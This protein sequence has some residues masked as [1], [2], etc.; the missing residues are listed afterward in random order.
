M[1]RRHRPRP[2][3]RHQH[4]CAVRRLHPQQQPHLQRH[5]PI[6]FKSSLPL[7][8]RQRPGL[9]RDHSGNV[10]MHLAHRYQLSRRL[11]SHGHHKPPPVLRDKRILIF[12]G[13]P[14]I[15]LP[16]PIR[17]RNP[18]HPRTEPRHQPR[19]PLP[20]RHS[21]TAPTTGLPGTSIFCRDPPSLLP[22]SIAGRSTQS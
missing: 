15:Q 17:P 21:Q 16:C 3:I 18:A 8:R 2:R 10:P 5:Q 1:E 14:K 9:P 4:R 13:P 20:P 7:R 22:S 6:A 11:P 19:P 12:R